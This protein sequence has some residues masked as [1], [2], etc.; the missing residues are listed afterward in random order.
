[1]TAV[2]GLAD[3]ALSRALR[4]AVAANVLTADT[5]GYA[6]RHGLIR[7][8]IL[9]DLLPSDLTRLHSRFAEAL[10]ADPGL[11]PP[12]RAVRETAHHAYAAH[13]MQW[14]L[15]SSWL[16]AAEAGRALAHAEQLTLLDRV[17]ELW[18]KV[19]GAE[20]R[21]GASQLSVLE[22]AA[23]VARTAGENEK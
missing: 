1:L 7:E 5:D 20:Q 12:G 23:A 21:I 16:A 2:T 3:D 4:P 14:A 15:V 11:V 10:E 22:Q 6:F 8:A 9:D 13:D 17:L 19:P 18:D